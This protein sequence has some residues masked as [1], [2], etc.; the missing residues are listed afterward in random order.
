M[1]GTKPK[2][3]FIMHV[4]P[5]I[6]GASVV[7]QN[8]MNSTCLNTSFDAEYINL[9]TAFSLDKI[10]KYGTGKLFTL[11]KIQ[12]KIVKALSQT[13]FDLCYM[14]L[15]AGGSG[16]LKDVFIVSL[17]KFYKK[18]IIF[19]FHNKGISKFSGNSRH[20]RL[21]R[22]VFKNTKT[23]Q[24]SPLLYDDI[25]K[26]VAKKDVYFC[27]NGI[28]E[29]KNMS[30]DKVQVVYDEKVAKPVNILFLSNM[31]EEKGVLDLLQAC[32]ILNRDK[33][34]FKCHFVGAWSDIT[35][36]FFYKT[37]SELNL[38]DKIQAYGK[39]YGNDKD[40]FL[41]EADIFVLPTYYHNECLPL[42]LLEAMSRKLPIVSTKEG[43]IPDVVIDGQTGILFEQRNIHSLASALKHLMSSQELRIQMGHRGRE[44]FEANFTLEIFE[45]NLC[46]ILNNA[47]EDFNK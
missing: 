25:S 7:G 33:L 45:S 6:N 36:E 41:D 32:K 20:D 10:G 44:R 18:N 28:Q 29:D 35:E 30:I 14:T 5:P 27:P 2:I 39:M 43:A 21:Y 40:S 11:A 47:I 19:H 23:I 15:T 46:D 8:I 17:L 1:K 38:K 31:M 22:Y 16:F 26:Y 12:R 9:T 24:L 42:V 3:L 13:D 37:V 34:K 4:P